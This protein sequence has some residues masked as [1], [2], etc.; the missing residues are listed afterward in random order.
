MGE[1]KTAGT[2]DVIGVYPIFNTAAVL[3]HEIDYGE[4]R[5]LASINGKDP[6]WCDITEEYISLTEE[7]ELGFKFGEWFVP[8]SEVMRI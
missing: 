8:F 4:D 5:V 1:E 7:F 2:A 3:V 6:E